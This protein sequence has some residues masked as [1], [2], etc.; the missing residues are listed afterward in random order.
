MRSEFSL[1]EFSKNKL[2][3]MMVEPG[4]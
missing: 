4:Y 1:N 3:R 2:L